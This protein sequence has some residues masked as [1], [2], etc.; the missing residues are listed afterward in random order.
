M[1]VICFNYYIQF[2]G[3][4][5]RT[6]FSQLSSLS[7]LCRS[8]TNQN[9]STVSSA[10]HGMIKLQFAEPVGDFKDGSG[11]LAGKALGNL[12]VRNEKVA[13]LVGVVRDQFLYMCTPVR[14]SSRKLVYPYP[15]REK[16][17]GRPEFFIEIS[18]KKHSLPVALAVAFW[19]T[20][21]GITDLRGFSDEFIEIIEIFNQFFEAY[22]TGKP[23][24]LASDTE[25]VY[26]YGYAWYVVVNI[27]FKLVI[28]Q[29][30]KD[31]AKLWDEQIKHLSY[32]QTE[33]LTFV[34][35]FMTENYEECLCEFVS[36]YSSESGWTTKMTVESCMFSRGVEHAD[37]DHKRFIRYC[38]YPSISLPVDEHSPPLPTGPS[39]LS[40]SPVIAEP[41]GTVS[42]DRSAR[43]GRGTRKS[44]GRRRRAPSR[45]RAPKSS[46]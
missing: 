41:H 31:V 1:N 11:T 40:S 12:N 21:L 28:D 2:D 14:I 9:M 29:F 27:L 30:P 10:S 15:G 43:F 6:S 36:S 24:N 23:T 8:T 22:P 42:S 16:S 25:L 26:K 18:I 34:R 13:E 33:L 19:T 45:H 32:Q 35:S 38:V 37:M 3:L 44:S 20:L 4:P 7:S 46:S 39:P 17:T 5:R